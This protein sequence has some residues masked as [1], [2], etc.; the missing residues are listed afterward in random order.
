MPMIVIS[1]N[2]KVD[3]SRPVNWVDWLL[4]SWL[5]KQLLAILCSTMFKHVFLNWM[6]GTFGEKP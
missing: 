6:V 2:D 3:F 5:V 1:A 4:G